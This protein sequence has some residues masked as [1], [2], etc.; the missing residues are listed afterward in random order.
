L[1][2]RAF[3]ACTL[4]AAALD[5]ETGNWKAIGMKFSV[6]GLSEKKVAQLR[7]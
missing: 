3:L 2:S 7:G 4:A 1:R 6:N 5:T